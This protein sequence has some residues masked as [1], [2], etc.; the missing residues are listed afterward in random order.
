MS[1]APPD[2][3]DFGEVAHSL[4]RGWRW[5]GGAFV[6]SVA[7]TV[8]VLTFM[9]ARYLGTVELGLGVARDPLLASYGLQLGAGDVVP[10]LMSSET[11][12][13]AASLDTHPAVADS[14]GWVADQ[15][16]A[17]GHGQDA[18]IVIVRDENPELAAATA[19]A[20][21][22][23]ARQVR[24]ERLQ[25]GLRESLVIL[26]H[27]HR[28]LQ[29][30]LEE[31]AEAPE[32]SPAVGD[33]FTEKLHAL[34]LERAMH[35]VITLEQQMTRVRSLMT[36]PPGDWTVVEQASPG[37]HTVRNQSAVR[38]LAAVLIPTLLAALAWLI[39]DGRTR[40]S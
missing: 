1:Q 34:R 33:F 27:E 5:I 37:Q 7:A 9:P 8:A 29:T 6:V 31:L 18:V 12:Q 14:S 38:A 40:R 24:A 32:S 10:L 20:V 21:E 36:D 22:R 16:T 25:R 17:V 15:V 26:E 23:A 11:R 4:L 30:S 35:A 39:H 19:N 2:A 3:L 13:A 28:S